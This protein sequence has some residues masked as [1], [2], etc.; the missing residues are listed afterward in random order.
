MVS[1][2]AEDVVGIHYQAVASEDMEVLMFGVMI[3]EYIDP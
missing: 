2:E 3:L 1:T